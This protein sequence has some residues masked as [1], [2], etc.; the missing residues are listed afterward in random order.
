MRERFK[1]ITFPQTFLGFHQH[2]LLA[3]VLQSLPYL[4]HDH[5]QLV[6]VMRH[7]LKGEER[8]G[9][10]EAS[11]GGDNTEKNEAEKA[12]EAL[13][14]DTIHDCNGQVNLLDEMCYI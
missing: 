3:L 12:Q 4:L 1:W 10:H 6:Q 2:Y 8:T 5:Q 11:V 9:Q 7:T 13:N 14:I